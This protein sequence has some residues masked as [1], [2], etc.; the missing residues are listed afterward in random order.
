MNWLDIFVV[1]IVNIF[2]LKILSEAFFMNFLMADSFLNLTS[3]FIGWTFTSISAGFILKNKHASISRRDGYLSRKALHIAEHTTSLFTIFSF[4]K[5]YNLFL[6]ILLKPGEHTASCSEIS[7]SV[8]SKSINFSS[9]LK[10]AF[11]LSPTLSLFFD[12]KIKSSSLKE[13]ILCC[14]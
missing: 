9:Y 13:K 6:Q 2:S 10:I 11:S 5:I 14:F 8:Y 4:M 1:S 3:L 7:P 12:S